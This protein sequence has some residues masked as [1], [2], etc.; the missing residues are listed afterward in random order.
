MDLTVRMD[1]LLT[2]GAA[3]AGGAETDGSSEFDV[4]VQT[5]RP[6]VFRFLLASLRDRESAENLTQDCFLRAYRARDQFRGASSRTTWVM[7]IAIN[8]VR[9][10]ESNSRL[11]FW[12]RALRP[13]LSPADLR[14][15]LPDHQVSPEAAVLA[16]EQVDAIWSVV[17]QLSER[18]RTVFLL[19]F[20]EDMDLLEIVGATGMR[21]GTVKTHLFRALQSVRAKLEVTK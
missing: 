20:V 17:T 9:K 21:E 6:R 1:T 14:E 16:K 8:L 10:H 13:G 11:K 18:Q 4:L 5:Y 3:D 19:R 15:W 7:Q 12:R 2:L